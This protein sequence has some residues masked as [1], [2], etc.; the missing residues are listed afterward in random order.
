[1][2]ELVLSVDECAA[3][4]H[5]AVRV[6]VENVRK[7]LEMQEVLRPR[8]SPGHIAPVHAEGIVLEIKVVIFAVIIKAVRIVQPAGVR[9]EVDTRPVAGGAQDH[10][11]LDHLADEFVI[12]V[13]FHRKDLP[14]ILLHVQNAVEVLRLPGLAVPVPEGDLKLHLLLFP[15][16][17][18]EETRVALPDHR[19]QDIG[20]AYFDVDFHSVLRS[21]LIVLRRH[22][23]ASS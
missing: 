5:G 7:R 17:K 4:I 18:F 12:T 3:R 6:V 13:R 15:K 14:L 21:A 16:E 11:G 1:M 2:P 10:V 23:P 8:M 9:R 19:D 22:L 20:T